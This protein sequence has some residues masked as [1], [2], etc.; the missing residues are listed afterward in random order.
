MDKMLLYC[1][2]NIVSNFLKKKNNIV[3]NTFYQK[4]KK[5]VSN[6][7]NNILKMLFWS[8]YFSFFLS[9]PIF[10]IK[11]LKCTLRLYA[12]FS[13]FYVLFMVRD[14]PPIEC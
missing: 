1:L 4:K 2:N 11:Q 10:A 14:T 6:T 5:V 8:P 13:M 9:F 7:S 3:S 12:S